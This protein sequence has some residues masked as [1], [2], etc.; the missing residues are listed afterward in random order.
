MLKVYIIIY[1]RYGNTLKFAEMIM[2]KAREF[3]KTKKIFFSE[4]EIAE[5][6]TSV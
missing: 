6:F 5:S 2:K 4:T 1:T 3:K